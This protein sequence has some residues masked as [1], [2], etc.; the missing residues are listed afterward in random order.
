LGTIIVIL[1]N[2]AG[3]FIIGKYVPGVEISGDIG[4]IIIV[5]IIFTALNFALK[6]VLKLI[7]G[8]FIVITLGLG[9]IAVNIVILYILDILTRNLTIDGIALIYSAL[10]ISAINFLA[11]MAVKKK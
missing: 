9:L 6:P 5:G 3:F 11:H 10:I 7:L 2:S 1:V 4:Q 8:P